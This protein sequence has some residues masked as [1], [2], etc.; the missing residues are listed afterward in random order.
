MLLEKLQRTSLWQQSNQ[1]AEQ[2]IRYKPAVPYRAG[3]YPVIVG[4][5]AFLCK[6]HS[7]QG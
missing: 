3:E 4:E 2:D 7:T 1:Q 6:P 5:V